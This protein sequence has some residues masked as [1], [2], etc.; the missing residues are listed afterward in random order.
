MVVC[1]SIPVEELEGGWLG[2]LGFLVSIWFARWD[3]CKMILE[4]IK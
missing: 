2:M 1:F 4:T 3:R